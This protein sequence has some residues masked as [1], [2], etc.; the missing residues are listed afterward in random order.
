MPQDGEDD[1]EHRPDAQGGRAREA[2]KATEGDRVGDPEAQPQVGGPCQRQGP[3]RHEVGVVQRLLAERHGGR[4]RVEQ[5]HHPLRIARGRLVEDGPEGDLGDQR[6]LGPSGAWIEHGLRVDDDGPLFAVPD[7][8]LDLT[9]LDDRREPRRADEAVRSSWTIPAEPSPLEVDDRQPDGSRSD[10]REVAQERA[11]DELSP[12]RVDQR[13][14]DDAVAGERPGAADDA[15]HGELDPE[16]RRFGPRLGLDEDAVLYGPPRRQVA[17]E[18]HGRPE[19]E[20]ERHRRDEVLPEGAGPDPRVERPEA[21][22]EAPGRRQHTGSPGTQL[23]R[24]PRRG[25]YQSARKSSIAGGGLAPPVAISRAR[26]V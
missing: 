22:E 26:R 16:R 9:P 12:L 1:D 10:G 19:D 13:V 8:D 5:G 23:I 17:G 3:L 25:I 18:H 14:G 20:R 21:L 4:V 2:V 11:H 24:S 6:P 15:T 7:G